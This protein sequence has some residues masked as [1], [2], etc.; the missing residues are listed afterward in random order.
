MYLHILLFSLL[1]VPSSQRMAPNS[2]L[3]PWKNKIERQSKMADLMPGL[4][5]E[6]QKADVKIIKQQN[7]SIMTTER[8]GRPD[9]QV[10][11]RLETHSIIRRIPFQDRCCDTIDC[12]WQ[13]DEVIDTNNGTFEVVHLEHLG[14]YQLLTVGLCRPESTC[15]PPWLKKCQEHWRIFHVL[16]WLQQSPW[17]AFKTVKLPTRCKCA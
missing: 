13:L 9:M 15:G 5:S 8:P 17:Y 12:Y 11:E 14:Q 7:N 16:V 6:L 1:I 4:F 3:N 2:D 10:T